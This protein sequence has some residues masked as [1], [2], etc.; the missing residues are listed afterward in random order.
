M[1]G[2]IEKF[3][4]TLS[5]GAAVPGALA[6]LMWR[7]RG[8]DEGCGDSR[9]AYLACFPSEVR[10]QRHTISPDGNRPQKARA[11]RPGRLHGGRKETQRE[12]RSCP[13]FCR[14]VRSET[15]VHRR[16]A[17]LPSASSVRLP[18][19]SRRFEGVN[20]LLFCRS[21]GSQERAASLEPHSKQD[22]SFPSSV[23]V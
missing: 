10:H 7:S 13:G 8:A 18:R 20:A 21:A 17:P 11:G 14:E 4:D 22:F 12:D 6:W 1:C 19:R 2:L 15:W 9:P 5:M 23:C 16:R 3:Q